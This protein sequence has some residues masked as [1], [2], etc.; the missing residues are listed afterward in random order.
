M[1]RLKKYTAEI[2]QG[3]LDWEELD[4]LAQAESTVKIRVA[5]ANLVQTVLFFNQFQPDQSLQEWL[6]FNPYAYKLKLL[7]ALT[8]LEDSARWATSSFEL[9][10]S[11]FFVEQSII[12]MIKIPPIHDGEEETSLGRSFGR[13]CDLMHKICPYNT[14]LLTALERLYQSYELSKICMEE[15]RDISNCSRLEYLRSLTRY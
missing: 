6:D 15:A 14:R 12:E 7:R 9:S 10:D 3:F 1:L 2:Y 8:I 11:K 13:V 5:I 4:N